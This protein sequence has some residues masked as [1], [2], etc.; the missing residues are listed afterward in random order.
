ME[1]KGKI[2]LEF[3]PEELEVVF[4]CLIGDFSCPPEFSDLV[5]RVY[6]SWKSDGTNTID[7]YC[8]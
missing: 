6:E 8:K 3:T 2:S 7:Y 5:N 4:D 1:N